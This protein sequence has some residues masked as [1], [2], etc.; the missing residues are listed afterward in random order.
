M[1]SLFMLLLH[2]TMSSVLLV[3][4]DTDQQPVVNTHC[5]PV[6]GISA[7]G[8]YSFRGIPYAVPPLENRRWRPPVPLSKSAGTCWNGTFQASKFGNSCYQRNPFNTSV[9]CLDHRC[10]PHSTEA[11]DG[12]A[13]RRI[14]ATV[15]C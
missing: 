8:G 10:E 2:L 14:T 11:S 13:A 7:D 12:M 5:G 15:Q 9:K 4:Q 6:Q 1:F 3:S